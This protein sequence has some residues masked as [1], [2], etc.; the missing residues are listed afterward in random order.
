MV[1]GQNEN[2]FILF[3][4]LV[5][6]VLGKWICSIVSTLSILLF[7]GSSYNLVVI[8]IVV[9]Y[10]SSHNLLKYFMV[11]TRL[12]S[13]FNENAFPKLYEKNLFNEIMLYMN[14]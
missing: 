13:E 6:A 12:L 2:K 7:G 5:F 9:V 4:H 3:A 10:K 1:H 11:P 14:L 8:L